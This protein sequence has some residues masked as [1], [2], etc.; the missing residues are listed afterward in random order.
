VARL[1]TSGAEWQDLS[2]GTDNP[3]GGVI[4]THVTLETSLQRSGA[5]CWKV[6]PTS[7]IAAYVR[8]TITGALATNYYAR[9]YVM[10]AQQADAAAGIPVMR[11][12]D[13]AAATLWSV[14]VTTVS[15][16]GV[17]YGIT[18]G[19]ESAEVP[20][21]TWARLEML[22]N[23]S[24]SAG[25][26]DNREF[27]LNGVVVQPASLINAGTTAPGFLRIGFLSAPGTSKIMY[28]DDVAIND[29]SG[30]AQNSYPGDGKV[31]LCKPISDNARTT[32]WVT[33]AAGTTNLWD[34]V[35]NTPPV[36]VADTG[37]ATSQ[38]RNA[39]AEAS[40]SYD[41]NL[42]T[43]TTAGIGAA[44]TIN[45]VV[46]MCA[47]AAPVTT[48]SKQGL[49]GMASNPAITTVALSAT[50]TSGAF[51][52]GAAAATYPTGW[53]WSFGTTT[54]AP[55]VTK[56]NSPVARITQVTS[57]TRIADVCALGMYVDYTPAPVAVASIPN[58]V[59]APYTP[60]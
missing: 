59:M 35:N 50:G 13:G 47:T 36:G 12:L 49:I 26:D 30:A 28:I 44:D 19:N 31:V 7:S 2:S 48:S 58:V 38:I 34:A 43:Y 6:A 51:W 53:K 54:Y 20:Y 18:G 5:A 37:T 42:T 23:M 4:A 8:H 1:V 46:P 52:A 41:A 21:G 14:Q 17:T 15:A 32:G 40:A 45:V 22:I 25:V 10:F 39:T 56:G 57:S 9:A 11:W 55:S 16:T 60:A 29:G 24:G 3:D 33:G 27:V